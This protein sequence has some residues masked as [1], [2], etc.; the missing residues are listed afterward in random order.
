[1]VTVIARDTATHY[2]LQKPRALAYPK[3]VLYFIAGFIALVS[4]YHF[5]SMFY[6]FITR[7]RVYGWKKRTTMSFTRL[8]AAVADSFRTLA[9]RWTIPVGSSQELNLVEVGLSLGYIA[10]LFT[11]TFANSMLYLYPSARNAN[12]HS[13]LAPTTR[14]PK[15]SA[16]Y[17][18]NRAGT[19]TASQLPI[20]VA[21]G[22]K[23]NLISCGFKSLFYLYSLLIYYGIAGLTGVNF[24][25]VLFLISFA[26]LNLTTFIIVKLLAPY[27]GT[28]SMCFSMDSCRGSC[29]CTHIQHTRVR[30][31]NKFFLDH[32]RASIE[33]LSP[34]VILT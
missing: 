15:V 22:M 32:N 21:L 26:A 34:P 13:N 5:L 4:L 18:A 23:N 16:R 1:M 31:L 3:H 25:R 17:Y 12:S 27:I 19:M 7:K 2:V 30:G 28:S 33:F 29:K 20:M 24:A 11:W 8:P 9:F 6:S 10:I 14:G